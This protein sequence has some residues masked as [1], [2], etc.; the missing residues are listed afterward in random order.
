MSIKAIP[1][2]D[3]LIVPADNRITVMVP[4]AKVFEH[5]GQQMMLVPHK[6]DETKLLRNL[7]YDVKP[8]VMLNY[9]WPAPPDKPAFDAQKITTSLI[10]VNNRCY[11]LNGLGTGKTRAALYAFDYMRL[12]DPNM[13]KLLVT[14]PL[15]TLRQTWEKEVRM[16]FPHLSVGVLHGSKAKRLQV[17]D[18]DCD[19]FVIN[20]DGVEVLEEELCARAKLFGLVVLDEL[21]VYK[22]AQTKLWKA[23]N[24]FVRLVPRA[25]GMSATP[26]TTGATDAYG[27]LKMITP[28]VLKGKPFSRFREDVQKKVLQFKWINKHDAVEQVYSLMQPAVRFTRDECYDMPPCQKVYWD[29]PLSDDQTRYFREMQREDAVKSLDIKA[30]NAADTINKLLQIS[31]GLLYKPNHDP[32]YIDCRIRL[33]LLEQAVEQSDS[34]VIVFT[35]YKASIAMLRD[36][37]S[38]RWSVATISGDVNTGERERIFTSFMHTSDPHVLVAHPQTMSHGLTLTEAST[39]VWWGPPGSLETYEQ[40]NGRIT[41]AGQRHSQLI[42]HLVGSRLEQRIYN[43]LESRANVQQCLLDMFEAQDLEDLS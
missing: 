25:V 30:A 5:N 10:T 16:V 20:H 26:M 4:H 33:Q 43:L 23:T 7:G 2:R 34:K 12:T 1:Y 11:V 14:A 38:K 28:E 17:L 27:Q 18:S 42:V 21:S 6:L 32:H 35:P 19:I 15:S 24:R 31:L 29:A 36:L 9:S 41:R 22:N 37:L 8:P 3:H 40:A 39:I 13:G